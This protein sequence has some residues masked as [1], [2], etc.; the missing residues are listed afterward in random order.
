MPPFWLRLPPPPPPAA[1]AA[2]PQGSWLLALVL[3]VSSSTDNFAVGLSVALAGSKLPTRVNLII[4]ICNAAGAMSSAA[5]GALLGQAAP[6]LAP[7]GSAV[8]FLY[9]AWEELSSWKAGE[10]ASP[11]ARSAVD[12]MAWKL[13]APMTLNNLAGG[14]ASGVAGVSGTFAGLCALSASYFM[15]KRRHPSP[16]TPASCVMHCLPACALVPDQG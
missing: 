12:G 10:S 3:A 16:S 9:L 5:V 2:L 6:T 1:W 11:L 7:L 4:A 13:A 8:I 15:S 14:V